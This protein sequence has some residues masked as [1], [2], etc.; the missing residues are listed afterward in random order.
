MGPGR[1]RLAVGAVVAIVVIA[2]AYLQWMR[3]NPQV[4][5][6]TS[7]AGADWIRPD[8]PMSLEAHNPS[9]TIAGFRTD[10]QFPSGNSAAVLSVGALGNLAV[11]LDDELVF[12]TNLPAPSWRTRYSI[13]LPSEPVGV[14]RL[15][16]MIANRNGPCLCI[17]SCSELGLRSGEKWEASIDGVR[18]KGAALAR[19]MLDPEVSSQFPSIGHCV[20]KMS[21]LLGS[22]FVMSFVLLWGGGKWITAWQLSRI[23]RWGILGA[24]VLLGINN[25]FKVPA[26]VGYDVV[27]HLRYIVYVA[28]SG[29]IPLPNEGWQFFQSPLYYIVS[30]GLY[31]L[32]LLCM[33]ANRAAAM[34][35]VV[36]L[37]CGA[38]LVEISYRTARH[39]FPGRSDLWVVSTVVGG[40]LP[41]NLY[42]GQVLSNEP[43]EACLSGIVA[44]LTFRFLA[45][46]DVA[47]DP[48]RGGLWSG[49]GVGAIGKGD[50]C[51]L[52]RAGLSGADGGA[53]AA[54]LFDRSNFRPRCGAIDDGGD[55]GRVVLP[56]ELDRYWYAVLGGVGCFSYSVVA[57]SG[58]SHAHA[59]AGVWACFLPADLWGR[60]QYLGFA[61][62]H[63]LG[64]WIFERCALVRVSTAVA[65]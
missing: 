7:E 1:R 61:L 19:S 35:R 63:A 37:I 49:I 42:M 21:P 3:G 33:T 30:A 39:V 12:N 52:D 8:E 44:L 9:V 58:I 34:L 29:R 45:K 65:F 55:S 10:I 43:M 5:L 51:Y 54:A 22:L 47:I 25:I 56:S 31:R 40:L 50:G 48:C 32:F 4:V 59:V 26:H 24:W 28:D 2:A 64:G 60:A 27:D 53:N 13:S 18:W 46:G 15:R 57:G 17:A 23:A 36:P 41:M 11:Y 20:L 38:S 62:F 16:L 14:H 6:L